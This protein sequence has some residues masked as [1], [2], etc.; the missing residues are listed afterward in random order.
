MDIAVYSH[1]Q[2]RKSNTAARLWVL[3]CL[4]FL[5]SSLAYSAKRKRFR[6]PKAGKTALVTFQNETTMGTR[7]ELYLDGKRCRHRRWLVIPR[8]TLKRTVRVRA[9][10]ELAF[11]LQLVKGGKNPYAACTYMVSFKP[12]TKQ[13]YLI[14]VRLSKDRKKCHLQLIR[15]V[16]DGIYT[17]VDFDLRKWR[18][19]GRDNGAFCTSYRKSMKNRVRAA[20]EREDKRYEVPP[21]KRRR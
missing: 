11:A 4:V 14:S 3:C 15:L 6:A 1:R 21:K 2:N 20:E 13:N 7:L 9:K 5:V 10:K 16:P 12:M 19:G 8:K 18:D 17:L